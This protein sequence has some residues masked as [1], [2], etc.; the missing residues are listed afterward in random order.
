MRR[1][2]LVVDDDAAILEVLE[3]RLS[4][5]GF[6]V[7][8]TP[9]A[10]TAVGAVLQTRFDLALLDLRMEPTD[11]IRLMEQL[12]VHQPRLPVLIMTAHGTIETAVEAV[13]RGAFDYLTK[14]F[15]RDELRAKIGRALAARRWARDRERLLFVGETLASSGR[16]DRVLESVAQ[17]AVETTEADRCIVFQNVD[18]HLVT[19]ATAGAPPPSW[20]ALETAARAAMD[21][22]VPT[23]F[24]GIE[25]GA[26]AAAPPLVQ[27]G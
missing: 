10:E 13:Q 12:H 17:A 18:G 16:M 2:M 8:A 19:A 26:I 24:P 15:V 1:K 22:G 6:D 11:G 21:K 4:S 14:P 23:T 5:M 20:P 7:T 27:L 25:T 3:M 9:E